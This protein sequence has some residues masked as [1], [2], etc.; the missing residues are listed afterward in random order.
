MAEF[1]Q[2]AT[3]DPLA[4]ERQVRKRLAANRGA[5]DRET[6]FWL[7]LSLVDLLVQTDRE[8]DS[9]REL[10][11]AR[12]LL[13]SGP[14]AHRQRLWLEFYERFSTGTPV[15]APAYQRQQARAREEAQ[16]VGDES[17]L[18]ALNMH[19]AVVQL[20]RDAV[21]EAWA[22]LEAVEACAIRLGDVSMQAYALGSM[23]PLA[24]RM[25]ARDLP[26]TYYQRA[27]AL[28]GQVPAR[29]KKAWLL[30]DLGWAQFRAGETDEAR[31]SFEQVLALSTEIADVSGMMRGHEGLAEVQLK[32]Q[33]AGSAL[34]HARAAL[35]QAAAHPGLRYRLATAQTQVVE[36]LTQLGRSAELVSELEVLRAVAVQDPSPRTGVLVSRSAA[37][38]LRVLGHHTE[39]YLELERFVELSA[40]DQRSQRERD[41]QRLQAHYEA[42]RREAENASLRH[43][44]EVSRLELQARTGRQRSL[45]AVVAALGLALAG[46]GAYFARA[47]RRRHRLAE[48][49]LRDELTGAPNRR[50]VLAFARE[51]LSLARRLDLPLSLALIDLDRFKQINDRYG[52]ATG[53]RVLEAFARAAMAELRGQDRLGRWGGEEWLLVM[54]GTRRDE[55]PAVFQRLRES[56]AAQIVAGLPVPHGVTF[57]MGTA[58]RHPGLDSV[59]ALTAEADRQLYRAKEQGRDAMCAAGLDLPP[60]QAAPHAA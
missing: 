6:A 8:A 47:L 1:G 23:G 53:D 52:H 41:A 3:D 35:A 18:C 55:M 37:R 46:G 42:A 9:R 45:W 28:L 29:F 48:L 32:Q 36:A 12:A 19:D 40:A 38:A 56:L 31:R 2:L 49:A 60:Q 34:Q 7:Q 59:E 10:A 27:L 44:A 43:A 17:L 58:E 33:D 30:D 11:H 24:G 50:A 51:Q 26:Q 21:D 13:P 57:S 5:S 20:E 54:P 25:G 4:A 39:A 16:A 15:D 22:T 14:A